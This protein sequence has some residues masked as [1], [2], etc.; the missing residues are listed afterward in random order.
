VPVNDVK[1]MAAMRS[2]GTS[3]PR[4]AVA[5]MSMFSLIA[6]VLIATG[7]YGLLTYAVLRRTRELG[8]RIA[9]GARRGVVGL[10]LTRAAKLTTTGLLVGTVGSVGIARLFAHVFP[11]SADPGAFLFPTAALIVTATSLLAAFIPASRAAAIDPTEAL[12]SE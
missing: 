1:T 7:V 10:V 11:E 4:F 12:R 3:A 8:I 5:L 6:I 2:A 9:L